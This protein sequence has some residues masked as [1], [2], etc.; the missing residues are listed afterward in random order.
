MRIVINQRSS[1][2]QKP[3]AKFFE[4][5]V[6]FAKEH[7]RILEEEHSDSVPESKKARIVLPYS[8]L[9][10][11]AKLLLPEFI[12]T[13][14]NGQ[15][16][17]KFIALVKDNPDLFEFVFTD[18]DRKLY[19]DLYKTLYAVVGESNQ[20]I[21]AES[22]AKKRAALQGILSEPDIT[23]IRHDAKAINNDLR[24]SGQDLESW[25]AKKEIATGE[26]FPALRSNSD[27]GERISGPG[28]F[29]A[30]LVNK[31]TK[32][33]FVDIL[34]N[35]VLP[36]VNDDSKVL[37]SELFRRAAELV[38]KI[39]K[40]I[41]DRQDLLL[42]AA[43][44]KTEKMRGRK[45]KAKIASGEMV[46]M[47]Q[48]AR[49]FDDEIDEQDRDWLVSHKICSEDEQE[50]LGLALFQKLLAN[51][52][53]RK[54]LNIINQID[55]C[56]D[57]ALY[58]LAMSPQSHEETVIYAVDNK[59]LRENAQK[60][61]KTIASF[62]PAFIPAVELA[63]DEEPE[64]R[65]PVIAEILARKGAVVKKTVNLDPLT[66]PDEDGLQAFE[67]TDSGQLFRSFLK[68][69]DALK[70]GEGERDESIELAKNAILKA[71][72]RHGHGSPIAR[73][74]GSVANDVREDALT[75][76]SSRTKPVRP[77]ECLAA[78]PKLDELLKTDGLPDEMLRAIDRARKIAAAQVKG[79]S[80]EGMRRAGGE[81]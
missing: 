76:F 11:K 47:R 20:A 12:E 68:R 4:M 27:T 71:A 39:N 81:S 33:H 63:E 73:T 10:T 50:K 7:N 31:M 29:R 2:D 16:E 13:V 21:E 32:S 77:E 38:G 57:Q 36:D 51:N 58:D 60:G 43:G 69:L 41:E 35:G 28:L 72:E 15:E 17:K 61:T 22:A 45:S 30:L 66:Q 49:Q 64:D 52:Q 25:F 65:P 74:I 42:Q 54:T 9:L 48:Q 3:N 44:E 59:F 37:Y 67:V 70:N 56:A 40:T 19:K 18:A 62:D 6:I 24:W 79:L 55:T 53:L 80:R 75:G 14:K 8:F 78:L 1:K 23:T 46:N 5:A 34:P 26:K